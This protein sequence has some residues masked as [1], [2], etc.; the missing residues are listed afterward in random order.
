MVSEDCT[1]PCFVKMGQHDAPKPWRFPRE[2]FSDDG[3]AV[4]RENGPVLLAPQCGEQVRQDTSHL[5]SVQPDEPTFVPYP[6][7]VK[8]QNRQRQ[9]LVGRFLCTRDGTLV[10]GWRTEWTAEELLWWKWAELL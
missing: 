4:V 6:C 8:L 9:Q 2:S 7:M 5:V 1:E 3:V 10:D